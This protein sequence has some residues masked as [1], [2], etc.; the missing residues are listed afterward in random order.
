MRYVTIPVTP[1]Q[2]NCSLIWCEKT[3][4]AAVIDPGG[5]IEK[6]LAEVERQGVELA[7]ILLTHAHFDHVGGAVELAKRAGVEIIG[8]H[9]ADQFLLDALEQQGPAFGFPPIPGFRPDRWLAAGDRIR[10]GEEE[11]EV[12]HCPGHSPG[13]VVFFHRGDQLA[14]VGDVLF[15]GA[16]G[17]TDL[18]GGDYPSLIRSIR[19]KLFPLGDAVTFIPGHGPNSTFGAERR[20]NP[21]VGDGV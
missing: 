19:E 12:L 20:T 2:Q 1:L 3:R 18:P 15:N 11:L 16:I 6:I 10:V 4:Q 21:F 8:P 5:E 13:H 9:Q 14:F 7:E 17:R